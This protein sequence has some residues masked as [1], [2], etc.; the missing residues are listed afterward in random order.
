[1]VA[2]ERVEVDEELAHAGHQ[3]H[4]RL[5]P[6]VDFYGDDAAKVRRGE[7]V[8]RKR[9]WQVPLVGDRLGD[10]GLL[11]RVTL[12]AAPVPT[13]RLLEAGWADEV[14]LAER[15]ALQAGIRGRLYRRDT[16]YHPSADAYAGV[17]KADRD[18]DGRGVSAWATLAYDSPDPLVFPAVH[19]ATVI[20][21]QATL[22][23]PV[24]MPPP[25]PTLRYP[26]W[27]TE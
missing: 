2:Q 9:I 19:D 4:L 26:S 3:R 13:L 6:D 27:L 20:G 15:A 24:A 7:P 5:S 17:F 23:N 14:A 21:L 8:E 12:Q 11:A 18:R 22:G 10:T 25:V 16:S 1:M